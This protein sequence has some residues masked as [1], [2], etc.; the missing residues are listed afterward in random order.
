MNDYLVW[1]PLY[2]VDRTKY[3]YHYTSVEKHLKYYTIKHYNLLT[4]RLLMT[5]LNKSQNYLL[6][7][8]ISIHLIWSEQ[9]KNTF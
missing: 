3:L 6:M 2:K 9:Y 8:P 4:L 5:F 1:S 7:K